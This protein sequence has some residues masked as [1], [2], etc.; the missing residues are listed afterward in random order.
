[1]GCNSFSLSLNF[2]NALMLSLDG[3]SFYEKQTLKSVR[4]HPRPPS[5]IAYRSDLLHSADSIAA[6]AIQLSEVHTG[7][8][9]S[10]DPASKRRVREALNASLRALPDWPLEGGAD[11]APAVNQQWE[12]AKA[13]V[14]W[15]QQQHQAQVQYAMATGWQQQQQQQQLQPQPQQMMMTGAAPAGYWQ[16]PQQTGWQQ[17]GGADMPG[18]GMGY[19]G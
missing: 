2:D 18:P 4:T 19:Y 17:P 12:S 15:A 9:H 7:Y 10:T 1:V 14:E 6:G 5:T 13:Q 8:R 16:Q 3:N 11:L